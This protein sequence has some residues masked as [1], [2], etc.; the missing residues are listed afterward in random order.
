MSNVSLHATTVPNFV[1]QLGEAFHEGDSDA[2][3]KAAEADNVRRLQDVYR[4]LARGDFGPFVDLLADDTEMEMLGPP[5]M[6]MVGR[7][8]GKAQVVEAVGRNFSLLEDQQAQILTLVA[9]GAMV[10]LFA[11]E[12]GGLR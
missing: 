5:G 1:E 8:S 2:S 6:P 10:V 12:C 3:T 7:W 11:R 9:Q 4:A